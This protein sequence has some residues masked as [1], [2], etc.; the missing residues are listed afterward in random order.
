VLQLEAV[1]C[2]RL[3]DKKQTV[4]GGKAKQ[5]T[6]GSLHAIEQLRCNGLRLHGKKVLLLRWDILQLQHID[7]VA[8]ERR[9]PRRYQTLFGHRLK[10]FR[11]YIV[12]G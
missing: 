2:K 1:A 12:I 3:A 6:A 4:V 7:P 10:M 11:W 9:L 5:Q 8:V